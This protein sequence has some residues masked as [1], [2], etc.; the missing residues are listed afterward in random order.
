MDAAWFLSPPLKSVTRPLHLPAH[1]RASGFGCRAPRPGIPH[2]CLRSSDVGS[3]KVQQH[4]END[5]C[6]LHKPE[7]PPD[8]HSTAMAANSSHWTS[9]SSGSAGSCHRP[10][11]LIS[12]TK[13]STA[14]S[15]GIPL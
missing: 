12:P 11:S 5:C 15:E 1:W 13:L 3:N 6:L 4:A 10:C 2:S 9:S 8:P 7:G 14:S